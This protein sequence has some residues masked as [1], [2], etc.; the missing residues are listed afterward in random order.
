MNDRGR[1]SRVDGARI[2]RQAQHRAMPE[3]VQIIDAV[4]IGCQAHDQ[5]AAPPSRI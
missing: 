1:E 5:A 3:Q 4:R 2:R